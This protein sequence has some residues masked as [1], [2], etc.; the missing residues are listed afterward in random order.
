MRR[1]FRFV[2]FE[3]GKKSGAARQLTGENL[4]PEALVL[5]QVRDCVH[6]MCPPWRC[7]LAEPRKD[8]A[9]TTTPTSG[10]AGAAG[11]PDRVLRQARH[12]AWFLV[13]SH[14]QVLAEIRPPPSAE[15]P[16]RRPGAL[17][18]RIRMAPEFDT[19]PPDVLATMEGEEA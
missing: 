16:R 13:T 5:T 14:G 10:R 15:R 6:I 19:L 8:P 12:G 3:T 9:G 11:E 4:Y 1:A 17:R 18:G 2:V 7:A